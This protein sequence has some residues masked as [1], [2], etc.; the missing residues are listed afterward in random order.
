MLIKQ[1]DRRCI[2]LNAYWDIDPEGFSNFCY[3]PYPSEELET[4][5]CCNQLSIP[6][7][8][9]RNDA[10]IAAATDPGLLSFKYLS[11]L[12]NLF[13][14]DTTVKRRSSSSRHLASRA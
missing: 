6:E 8:P 4:E 7:T 11:I 3:D 13:I 1:F 14:C 10:V 9:L 5:I 12:S 2:E